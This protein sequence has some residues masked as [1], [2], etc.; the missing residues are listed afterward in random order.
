MLF[1][2]M[3]E[4]E[5][6][7]YKSK[8]Y[9][10]FKRLYH[11]SFPKSELVPMDDLIQRSHT[12]VI[13]FYDDGNFVGFYCAL[14]FNDILNILYLSI[15]ENERDHGYGSKLLTLIKQSHLN[16]RIIVDV[17]LPIE[18]ALNESQ[19]LARKQFYYRNGFK[20]TDIKYTW[21]DVDYQILVY[22]GKISEKEYHDF[23]KNLDSKRQKDLGN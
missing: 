22:N 16:K 10:E 11:A 18:T 7:T 2:L 15:E 12:E 5:P 9:K 20:D 8:D 17:E 19:R 4:T 1:I 6:I 13:A 21:K 14:L 3:I 23:W